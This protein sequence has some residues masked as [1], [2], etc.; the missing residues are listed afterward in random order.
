VN[1][2]PEYVFDEVNS[3]EQWGQWSYWFT[4]D[5]TMK[6]TYGDKRSGAG[7]YYEWASDELGNGKASI[8]ESIPFSSIK[9]DLHFMEDGGS[10][11]AWYTF[12]PEGE[13][14]KVTMGFTSDDH[15]NPIERWI[16]AVLIKPEVEKSCDYGLNKLKELA[17][18]KPRFTVPISVEEVKPFYYVGLSHTMNPQDMEAVGAQMG[19]MYSELQNMLSKAKVEIVGPPLCFFPS[20]E[21]TS[22]EMICAFKV[23]EGAKVSPKYKV[24]T[25][26]GG[27]AVKAENKGAYA[28]LEIAHGEIDSYLGFKNLQV[29]GAPWEVYVTDPGNEPDTSKWVTEVYYP[30]D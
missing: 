4:L 25:F 15:G 13:G 3:L 12:E 29:N 21:E 23:A 9:A 7:A 1:A 14:T 8:T 22:M 26:P 20:Y 28:N 17:E 18:A 5:N 6:V 19:K 27:R 2:P 10:A 11:L 30:V 24:A 16:A